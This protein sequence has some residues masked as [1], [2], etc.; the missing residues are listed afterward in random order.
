MS[1]ITTLNMPLPGVLIYFNRVT[2]IRYLPFT[3]VPIL[4]IPYL[5]S[6]PKRWSAIAH[7]IGHYL[8]WNL[9]TNPD[10]T[11]NLQEQVKSDA[12]QFLS[13]AGIAEKQQRFVMPWLEEIFSDVVGARTDGLGFV[14]S[15][16]EFTRLQAGNEAETTFNDGHHPP[17]LLRPFVWRRA[18]QVGGQIIERSGQDRSTNLDARI[19]F[20]LS[21]MP[22]EE[23]GHHGLM[24]HE[25]NVETITAEELLP[26]M[27]ILVDFL[28]TKLDEI[29][30]DIQ[31]KERT[32][33]AFQELKG[34]MEYQ[35]TTEKGKGREVYELLLTPR[36]LEGGIEHTH[37]Y[38][39]PFHGWHEERSHTH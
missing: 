34:I 39:I 25:E 37:G 27:E 16:E 4:G 12:K 38:Y 22:A 3:R 20:P 8:F 1:Y 32:V 14:E 30:T 35:Q 5:F 23:I 36:V 21:L 18:L 28:S 9:G 17:L 19:K 2:N 31:P 29:L 24:E 7:E 6:G 15:S 10:E 11:L 33:T 26:A 13:N